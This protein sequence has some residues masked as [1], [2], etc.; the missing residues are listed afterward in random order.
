MYHTTGLHRDEIVELTERV[1]AFAG[2][3]EQRIE[4]PPSLGLF[5][6]VCIALAYL[7]RNYRQVE[8]AEWYSTSQPTVSRA[9]AAVTGWLE[10]TLREHV[11]VADE[12]RSDEPLLIDGTL[13]PCWSWHDRRDLYSG[14]HKTTGM[15][16]QVA[17]DL[18]GRLRWISDPAPGSRHDAKAVEDTGLLHDEPA[19]GDRIGDKGY[20]GKGLLTPIRKPAHRALLDWEKEFNAAVNALRAPVERAIAN[21][22]TWRILHTDYRR[23]IS[24]FEATISTVI[25]LE[26]FRIAAE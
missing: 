14:K 6:C 8:L 26:F 3:C 25:A 23:P 7:R 5:T 18:S 21:L 22:K 9:I 11:P 4:F 16:L 20:I 24:T 12:L 1:E 13:V 2:A 19:A 15:N 17:T 10:Q